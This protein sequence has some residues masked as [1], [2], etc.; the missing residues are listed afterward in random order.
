MLPALCLVLEVVV[1][2]VIV[3][4]HRRIEEAGKFI[5]VIVIEGERIKVIDEQSAAL[6]DCP[7]VVASMLGCES[8]AFW[9]QPV[10]VLAEL[11]LSMRAHKRGGTLLVVPGGSAAWTESIVQPLNYVVSPPFSGLADLAG[12]RLDQSGEREWVDDLRR[13]VDGVAGLTAVDGATIIT[14]KYEVLGFGA[15]IVRRRGSAA[16]E[17]MVLTEPIE[18]G[19][20]FVVSPSHLG[21][22]R[23][24]SA[25][26]FVSDQR[27][28]VAL[29]ASQDGRFTVLSWSPT[30]GLVRAHRV[31]ALLL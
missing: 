21:G 24:L 20:P 11:A 5:N 4:K 18:G 7:S 14:D 1:P 19:Q 10:N 29:V 12:R 30:A 2:G 17:Q 22:T 3:I 23:H 31:E 26:Q 8:D 16:V 15:K 28:C 13:L 27:D 6:P 9:T 25:A